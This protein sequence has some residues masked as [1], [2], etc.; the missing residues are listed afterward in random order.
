MPYL[1]FFPTLS[2]PSLS[3]FFSLSLSLSLFLSL[4]LSFSCFQSG[5]KGHDELD[6]LMEEYLGTTHLEALRLLA[7]SLAEENRARPL[8]V[9]KEQVEERKKKE[10]EREREIERGHEL[11]TFFLLFFSSSLLLL[12]FSSSLL[13]L[14]FFSS[15][16]FSGFFSSLP[17]LF[18]FSICPFYC[19]Q[20]VCGV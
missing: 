17:H 16:S 7:Q 10:R 12:F 2:P 15:L 4:F 5:S 8:T 3:L 20:L 1:P 19:A 11:G 18:T 13:L 14:L 6:N 9:S